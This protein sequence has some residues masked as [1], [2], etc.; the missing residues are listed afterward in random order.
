M[1]LFFLLSFTALLFLYVYVFTYSSPKEF[2]ETTPYIFPNGVWTSSGYVSIQCNPDQCTKLCSDN[3]S[4]C[5][6]TVLSANNVSTQRSGNIKINPIS[7]NIVILI[8]CSTSRL[9]CSYS[10][11]SATTEV[12]VEPNSTFVVES[13]AP[14]STGTYNC[15]LK[16]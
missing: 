2:C 9:S 16:I 8:N 3:T 12:T 10:S 6:G 15:R 14:S 4:P 5:N 7:N 1:Q 13:T 11:T